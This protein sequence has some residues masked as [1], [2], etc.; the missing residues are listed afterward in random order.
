MSS[1]QKTY[2]NFGEIK[3]IYNGIL[4]ESISTGNKKNKNLFKQ[5]VK[6]LKENEAL[7]T[8]FF[9][10]N[11]I[12]N[13]IESDKNKAIEF[14]KENISLMNKF[15]KKEISEATKKLA[16]ELINEKHN[17]YVVSDDIKK[18]Y[19]NI[20]F[21]INTEKNGK[22]IGDILE[23]THSVADYIIN[24]KELEPI[25]EGLEDIVIS[26]KELG[27]LMVN[28]FNE[29][30]NELSESEREI[31]KT[32]L[33]STDENREEL[34]S[35]SIKEC[36][37]LVNNKINSDETRGE[38]EL[39]QSLLALKENLLNRKYIKE[40]FENDIIKIIELKESLK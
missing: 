20:S 5:Y 3:T 26:T 28:K 13:K 8:Q 17:L 2:M 35:N 36:L 21:L 15:S 39:Y 6:S 40:S 38:L 32:I 23:A 37:D 33:E 25:V 29:R 22:T 14:V 9:I 18:L 7:K 10:F 34:Y 11:N 16:G 12:E 19:E 4:A 24:N 1:K 30:Y 27:N 31:F